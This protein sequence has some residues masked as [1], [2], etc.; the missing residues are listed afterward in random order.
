[1]NDYKD[2]RLYCY[3]D[4]VYGSSAHTFLYVCIDTDKYVINVHINNFVF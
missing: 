4:Y 1:M 3:M 2:K